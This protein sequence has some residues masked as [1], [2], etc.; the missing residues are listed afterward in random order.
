VAV[1]VPLRGSLVAG[2]FSSIPAE[3]EQTYASEQALW[4]S[5]AVIEIERALAR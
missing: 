4:E 2:D 1:I 5:R 3:N